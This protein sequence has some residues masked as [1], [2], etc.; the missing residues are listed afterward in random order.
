MAEG[1][2]KGAIDGDFGK[3]TEE[4]VKWYQRSKRAEGKYTGSI[5]GDIDTLTWKCLIGF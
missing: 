3:M 4:A 1:Y 2:Y 5:D